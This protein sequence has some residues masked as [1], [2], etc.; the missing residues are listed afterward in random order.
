[1]LGPDAL[2][3]DLEKITNTEL[4]N[5]LELKFGTT[6]LKENDD[7]ENCDEDKDKEV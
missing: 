7:K 6:F 5:L 3:I 2:S 4:K 1:M